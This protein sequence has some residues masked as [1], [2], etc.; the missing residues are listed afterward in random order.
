MTSITL[1]QHRVNM[2]VRV[3]TRLVELSDPLKEPRCREGRHRLQGGFPHPLN[4]AREIQRRTMRTPENY[5]TLGP[6]LGNFGA[7]S[8][9]FFFFVQNRPFTHRNRQGTLSYG[10]MPTRRSRS[11]NRGSERRG[12]QRASTLR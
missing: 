6:A 7:H 11:A 9:F 2:D 3:T 12:S 4:A 10:G 5:V 1:I 8:L